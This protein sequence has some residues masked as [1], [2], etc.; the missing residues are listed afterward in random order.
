MNNS[1]FI[2]NFDIKNHIVYEDSSVI[3][4]DKPQGL[5][6]TFGQKENLCEK[7]FQYFP[8]LQ[9]IEGYKKG[10]GGLLNRLDNDTG[11]LVL[12][13]RSNDA[14]LYY[15]EKMKNMQIEKVYAAVVDG[16]INATSGIIDYPIAH[17]YKN[18]AKMVAV[19]NGIKYRG[20]PREART[21]WTLFENI[22]NNSVLKVNIKK[23]ARHQIRVHLASIGFPIVGDKLYNKKKSEYKYHLLYANGLKFISYENNKEISLAINVPFLL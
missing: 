13:A 9:K 6:T 5:S 16:K 10:E 14:F 3:I 11:G 17:H 1:N 22:K 20:T 19:L 15:S 7:A 21:E 4:F 2:D 23:G 12:F 18:K 8:D